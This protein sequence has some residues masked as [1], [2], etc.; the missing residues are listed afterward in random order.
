MDG[1]I[2]TRWAP[3]LLSVLRIVVAFLY[4]A[5]GTQKLWGF[6]PAE[7]PRAAVALLSLLGLAA[8]IETFGGLLMLLGLFTRPVAFIL[9]GEMAAAYF[10]SH[11]PRGFW[12]LVNRGEP[13]VFFCFTWLYFAAT[14]A[15]PWSLD[16]LRRPS[17]RR[18]PAW[19]TR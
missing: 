16:A 6:P 19:L 8:V 1:P 17:G 14:G 18:W 2:P 12:P 9:A 3:Y 13:A 4:I 11:V 10:L 5:H 7:P 15:G